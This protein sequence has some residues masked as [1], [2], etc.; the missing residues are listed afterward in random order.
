MGHQRGRNE[1][2]LLSTLKSFYSVGQQDI[3]QLGKVLLRMLL[4]NLTPH[5]LLVLLVQLVY[6]PRLAY[7]VQTF[8]MQVCQ[9]SSILNLLNSLGLLKFINYLF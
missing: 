3:Q 8:K 4:H 7:M 1:T 6:K 5:L 2:K 9:K